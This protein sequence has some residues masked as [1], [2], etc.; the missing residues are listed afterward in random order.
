MS[1]YLRSVSSVVVCTLCGVRWR[2]YSLAE[3][4]TLR[5][6]RIEP[7][8][9]VEGG[10]RWLPP[11]MTAMQLSASECPAPACLPSL[12]SPTWPALTSRIPTVCTHSST[13]QVQLL[14][15]PG[16]ME[17]S[18]AWLAGTAAKGTA[19]AD[20]HHGHER[21]LTEKERDRFED[22][23]RGLTV[24]PASTRHV[25]VDQSCLRPPSSFF[26]P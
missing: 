5:T 8:V 17:F 2:V 19:S 6:W 22:M 10:Q 20:R 25:M 3:G 16:D 21:L 24:S 15:M 12:S 26:L 14:Q 18:V 7:F 11:S 1:K 13:H 9:M 4:D 23:L